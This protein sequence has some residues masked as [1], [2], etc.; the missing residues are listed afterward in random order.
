MT[1]VTALKTFV[2][3]KLLHGFAFIG[4]GNGNFSVN[5]DGELYGGTVISNALNN[6]Q[7]K[8]RND[9][10]FIP[11]Y[12]DPNQSITFNNGNDEH[13]NAV[14]VTH[15]VATVLGWFV[16]QQQQRRQAR[17]AKPTR[18]WKRLVR[19]LHSSPHNPHPISNNT[20]G[21][22]SLRHPDSIYLRNSLFMWGLEH[23]LE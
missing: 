17:I 7:T 21:P 22:T 5:N 3:N 12:T 6:L 18:S 9:P 8:R 15:T 11:H 20:F 13:G 10:N 23:A 1:D 16:T 2:N 4:Q 19:S 14:N